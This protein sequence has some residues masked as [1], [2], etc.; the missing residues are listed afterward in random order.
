MCV[1]LW[2]RAEHITSIHPSP[3]DCSSR[4]SCSQPVLLPPSQ[5]LL[6]ICGVILRHVDE[7]PWANIRCVSHVLWLYCSA[8]RAGGNCGG[9][10]ACQR[11][12]LL[13]VTNVPV[14]FSLPSLIH[15]MSFMFVDRYVRAEVIAGFV[16]AL[17]LLFVAF[18]IFAE[19]IEV[20]LWCWCRCIMQCK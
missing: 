15:L 14:L 10:M 3:Q 11:T 17:F 8:G 20:S 18:F 9:K 6:C 16:N 19:A 13:W 2:K 12:L 4:P 5:S 7:Q 1:Y